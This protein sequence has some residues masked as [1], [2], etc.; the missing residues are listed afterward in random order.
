MQGANLVLLST[1]EALQK[2]LDVVANNI[3]NSSTTGFKRED[4]AFATY[5]SR[6]E[7]GQKLNFVVPRATF[8]DASSGPITP[9]N[10]PLDLAIQGQ[11][12]F[13]VRG[14]DGQPHFTR[15]GSFQ[16]DTQ[17]QIV[18]HAGE[19]VLG[20]GG[21]PITIPDTATNI[22]ISSDGYI[23]AKTDNGTSLAELGKI[24]VVKFDDEQKLQS[25]GAGLYTS[26][27]PSKPAVGSSVVQGSLE[28]SN[29]QAVTEMTQMIKIMR[30]YEQASSLISKEDDRRLDALTKLSKTTA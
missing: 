16:L 1:Q 12:Y 23:T 10:N 13:Q 17:G 26:S 27:D 7:S 8:R 24:A 29:V 20:D 3:A 22:N 30:S 19:L 21:Q 4:I 2:S 5:I 14:A 28:E 11:G 6:P 18:T 25:E 15:N 9:T